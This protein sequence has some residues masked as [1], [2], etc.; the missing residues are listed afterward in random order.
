MVRPD[1]FC[2]NDYT[3]GASL[4]CSSGFRGPRSP[5]RFGD[6]VLANNARSGLYNMLYDV[7]M[8]TA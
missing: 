5:S 1:N 4:R 7:N 8:A 2:S 3:A 6:V